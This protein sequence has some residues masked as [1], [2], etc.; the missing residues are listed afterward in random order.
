M[1]ILKWICTEF[2][3]ASRCWNKQEQF[4][5]FLKDQFSINLNSIIFK[6]LSFFQKTK[7]Q[8]WKKRQRASAIQYVDQLMLFVS[9]VFALV[10]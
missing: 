9:N 1:R 7:T 2:A 6:V 4:L 10:Y 8:A 3:H 5:I